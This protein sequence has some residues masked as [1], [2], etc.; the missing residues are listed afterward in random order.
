MFSYFS[1]EQRPRK[2]QEEFTL[3]WRKVLS[4]LSVW[5]LMTSRKL[6]LTLPARFVGN[7]LIDISV[8][9]SPKKWKEK[10][11]VHLRSINFPVSL[12]EHFLCHWT[13]C[14]QTLH[15]C[16]QLFSRQISNLVFYGNHLVTHWSLLV[17]L[18]IYI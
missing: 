3:T 17:I 5:P 7:I 14:N 9:A 8:P 18:P 12:K 1:E 15:G 13:N 10:L 11:T 4:W 6:A 2:Q 16:K